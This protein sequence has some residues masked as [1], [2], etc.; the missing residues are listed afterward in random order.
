MERRA[1]GVLGAGAEHLISTHPH[2]T[3]L[4]IVSTMLAQNRSLAISHL[5]PP[6]RCFGARRVRTIDVDLCNNIDLLPVRLA[7]HSPRHP[8][9]ALP[10]LPSMN[11]HE[12]EQWVRRWGGRG[13][14]GLVARCERERERELLG[15]VLGEDR[16]ISTAATTMSRLEI[17]N[18]K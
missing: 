4:N 5:H 1:D 16:N 18:N 10:A 13:G 2:S 9:L 14:D 11:S 7:Y 12:H 8:C 3:H 15:T 17:W 6:G